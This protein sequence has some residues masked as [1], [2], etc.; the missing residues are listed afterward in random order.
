MSWSLSL[1]LL[2]CLCPH[3]QLCLCCVLSLCFSLGLLTPPLPLSGTVSL[4]FCLF[5]QQ[6]FPFYCWYVF[7]VFPALS[8]SVSSFLFFWHSAPL[9]WKSMSEELSKPCL[10]CNS[11]S[12]VAGF[13][14]LE[15]RDKA[16]VWKLCKS[17]ANQLARDRW[18]QC[19]W[20]RVW[21]EIFRHSQNA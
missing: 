20:K 2:V 9:N 16:K 12:S 18:H 14:L 11:K 10:N 4:S 19:L 6:S 21:I 17:E 7:N 15:L 3:V 8:S 1:S 13:F 5:F